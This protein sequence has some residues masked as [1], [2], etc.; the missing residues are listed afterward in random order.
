MKLKE[1]K[2]DIYN[3]SA[4]ILN[5]KTPNY[6]ITWIIILSILCLLFITII[7]IPYNVYETYSGYVSIKDNESYVVLDINKSNFPINKNNKLYIHEKKYKYKV[8]SIDDNILIL[9]VNLNNNIKINNN[10]ISIN[11]LKERTTMFKKIKYKIKK[12]MVL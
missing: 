5:K 8:I 10:I 2:I 11:I 12:G 9:K 4:I 7:F 1:D 6:V 3:N